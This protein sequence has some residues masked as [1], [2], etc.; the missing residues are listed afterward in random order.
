MRKSH[1][2]TL[3]HVSVKRL[4]SLHKLR[5]LQQTNWE[6]NTITKDKYRHIF[7]VFITEVPAASWRPGVL[8][9]ATGFYCVFYYLSL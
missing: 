8:Q 1:K 6:E 3:C 7:D 5:A 2:L 9:K 4:L